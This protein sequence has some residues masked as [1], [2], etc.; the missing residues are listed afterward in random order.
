MTV[1]LD[2]PAEAELSGT[3]QVGIVLTQ[4]GPVAREH[5]MFPDVGG[6]P[7]A[8]HR[9]VGPA[10]R[11]STQAHGV[12]HGPDISIVCQAPP[13]L[14]AK[15]GPSRLTSRYAQR[16]NEVHQRLVHLGEV[17]H[18]G[19]PVVL[20]EVD[21]RGVVAAPWRQHPAV[22]ESLQIGRHSLG[23]RAGD[24]QVTGKLEIECL[25]LGVWFAIDRIS[26]ELLV[27]GQFLEMSWCGTQ[28]ELYPVKV[29]LIIARVTVQ[30]IGIG[31]GGH[32][33]DTLSSQLFVG[34][35][36]TH[37]ILVK[38]IET[39][40]IHQIDN[41]LGG[42]INTQFTT[43]LT[44]ERTIVEHRTYD[45]AEVDATVR[46]I[47]MLVGRGRMIRR[48]GMEG[49][50]TID[51]HLPLNGCGL[52]R[53]RRAKPEAHVHGFLRRQAHDDGRVG[54]RSEVIGR[55][56]GAAADV[57]IMKRSLADVKPAAIIVHGRAVIKFN[58]QFAQ[59]LIVLAVVALHLPHQRLGFA[60]VLRKEQPAHLPDMGVCL[61]IGHL[62]LRLSRPQGDVIQLDDIGPCAAIDGGSQRAVSDDERLLV[63]GGGTVVVERE[64]SGLCC[65]QAANTQGSEE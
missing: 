55:T 15:E 21:V 22:P 45:R 28:V 12:G 2:Q 8:T 9:P 17:G 25:Q 37:R 29:L 59:R 20:L 57:G 42:S 65:Q 31:H 58:H 14:H 53:Q 23:A 63:I 50:V 60:V 35:A 39:G 1:L 44:S 30:H 41:S 4:E 5:I 52:V 18:L 19:S 16:R 7:C 13:L 6:H 48:I 27:S 40:D 3:T 36:F 49:C 26:K 34:L 51:S 54:S 43:I 64:A 38:A 10:G 11:A 56:A 33:F 24:E 61:R 32:T 62:A 46:V 47:E